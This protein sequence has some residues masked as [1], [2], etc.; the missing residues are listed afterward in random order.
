MISFHLCSDHVRTRGTSR[1][2]TCPKE[3][4]ILCKRG[5]SGRVSRRVWFARREQLHTV[6]QFTKLYRLCNV[7]ST[8]AKMH[9]KIS[10]QIPFIDVRYSIFLTIFEQ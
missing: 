4:Q 2:R 6:C 3:E 8:S 1:T 9:C 10:L 7:G 5:T